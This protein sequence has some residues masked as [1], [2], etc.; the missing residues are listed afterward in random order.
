MG[1]A[2]E[3]HSDTGYHNQRL[4][5]IIICRCNRPIS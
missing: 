4:A 3:D 1:I 5:V 2:G